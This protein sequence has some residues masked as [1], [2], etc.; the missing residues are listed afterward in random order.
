M[1]APYNITWQ[2]KRVQRLRAW[3]DTRES[4]WIRSL[5][6]ETAKYILPEGRDWSVTLRI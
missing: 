6:E 2:T 1:V 5:N 4:T 3:F